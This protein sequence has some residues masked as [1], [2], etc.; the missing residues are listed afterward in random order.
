MPTEYDLISPDDAA[1]YARDGSWLDG[2]LTGWVERWAAVKP[3]TVFLLDGDVVVTWRQFLERSRRTAR[4]LLDLGVA[5]GDRVI[6]QLPN[7][8]E[9]VI[10]YAALAR[11]GAV[12]VPALPVYRHHELRHMID[13]TAARSIVVTPTF[14]GFEH[15]TMAR[16]LLDAHGSLTSIVVVRVGAE[17]L[18]DHEADFDSMSDAGAHLDVVDPASLPAMPSGDD[19]HII[20]FTSGTEAGAKGC[21]HTWNTYS[22]TPR[23]QARLYHFGDEDCELVPSPITHTAGLAGGILKA[24]FAGG[25]ACL[26]DVWEPKAALA[27]IARHRCTQA[28]GAT[29]FIAALVDAF[30]P[31]AHDASTFRLFICGGAPV[32]EELATRVRATLPACRLIPCFGQTEGLLITSCRPED[33]NEKV[34]SSDG[35]AVPGVD[36][37]VRDQHGDRLRPGDVGDIVYRSPGAMVRY[38]RNP[39]ASAAAVTE[40]GWRRTG[41]LGRMDADGYLRVTGR[42]KEMIIRGGLNIS[43]REIEELLLLHEAVAAVAIVG[44]PDALLGERAC[45][46]VVPAGAPPTLAELVRFL[47]EDHQ[48]A[49]P[50]LP[51]GLELFETLP[52]TLTGKV[53]KAA[54][55]DT[56]LARV[57]RAG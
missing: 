44:V 11:I 45:A 7:W 50:K 14:R 34:V 6:V 27:L 54:L 10:T 52:M 36:V 41:D 33:P 28:T 24:I 51:E 29:A 1:R 43:T 9:M 37:E 17:Q 13:L 53:Q 21:F 26:M 16:E 46:C 47:V 57:A 19:G 18:R 40:D 30:Q 22:Y 31:D 15:L 32:P 25:R 20:G 3:E 12:I 38:W 42:V 55:R 49:K 23:M 8:H 39:E 5:R 2:S 56:V 48:V 4:S 35:R